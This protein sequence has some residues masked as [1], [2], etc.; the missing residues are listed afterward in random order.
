MS[1]PPV[2]PAPY[3]VQVHS[4][5]PDSSQDG[6]PRAVQAYEHLPSVAHPPPT[7]LEN[8]LV[9]IGGLGDGPHTIPYVRTLALHLSRL[10]HLSYSVFEA[11]LTSSFTG[12][13]YSALGQDA[14]ELA[15]LVRYLRTRLGK[16]RVVL[17][18]HSTGCQDCL[19]YGTKKEKHLSLQGEEVRVDGF[20]LQ[21]PVSDRQ[22]I[23]M[24]ED[25]REVEAALRV[26]E[27]MLEKGRAEDAMER[28]VLPRSW[29]GS[30]VTAYRWCSLAGV[31]GDDDYFSSDLPDEKLEAIW[32]KLEVPV[33]I[34]PSEKDEWVPGWRDVP[35]LV[36]KWKSF[37]R[38]GIAS[39]LSGL[40][41]GANHRVENTDGQEWLADRVARF[42]AEIEKR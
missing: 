25:K 35:E 21:G 40:I 5:L 4:Y 33:L 42:L 9:F 22:A 34:V 23:A 11:R 36:D 32:G 41:P 16:K 39:E 24:T 6:P 37:C 29:R 26:A 7:Q 20:V 38:P 14:R 31:G 15:D 12:F 28:E 18:G 30:P 27:G 1:A 17:M 13:G 8:A 3:P 10:P 2:I 19:E